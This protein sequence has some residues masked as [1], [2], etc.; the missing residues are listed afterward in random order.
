MDTIIVIINII[1]SLILVYFAG[2]GL[3]F[4]VFGAAAFFYKEKAAR[5]HATYG[6]KRRAVV[7]IPAYKEDSVIVET[8]RAMAN[9]HSSLCNF[10]VCIIADSLQSETINQLGKL[11]V[12]TIPIDFAESTKSKAIKYCLEQLKSDYNYAIVL[13]ADNIPALGF[14]D[15]MIERVDAGFMVVQGHRTAKNK[16]TP[17]A[18]LDG[19]SEEVN[20][21]IFRKG[22]RALG[23]SASLIGSA[24]IFDFHLFRSM[25]KT[26][27][28]VGGFDKE[29]E[30]MLAERNIEIGYAENAI[31][32]DEKVQN[33]KGFVHQRRRWLAAQY[34]YLK[35][36]KRTKVLEDLKRHAFDYPDKAIQFLI[37]P[38]LLALGFT[39][40]VA[41]ALMVSKYNFGY[42]V[43]L[44]YGWAV[45]FALNLLAVNCFAN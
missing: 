44:S 3:Y 41:L 40:I 35:Q 15:R 17:I 20:N 25:M 26:S 6:T 9:H 22:H 1:S 31:V 10:D 32:Y 29:L 24:F 27:Q 19:I 21:S 34:N 33:S 28:S 2:A 38:R 42:D 4:L 11:A 30:L 14:V 16:N 37:P 5:S 23:I 8:A 12:Y 13:D 45:A 39:F 43:F 7:L 36:V 18:V